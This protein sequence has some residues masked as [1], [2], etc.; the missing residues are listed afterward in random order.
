[1][2]Y[3]ALS[4]LHVSASTGHPQRG[5]LQRNKILANSVKYVHMWSENKM[6]S[7]KTAKNV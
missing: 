4:L 2:S 6:L 5:H 7:I 3:I 1:M